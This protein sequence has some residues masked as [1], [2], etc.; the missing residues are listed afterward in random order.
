M[1]ER[2]YVKVYVILILLN[3]SCIG[4]LKTFDIKF[5]ENPSRGYLVLEYDGGTDLKKLTVA[6][7]KFATAF[8]NKH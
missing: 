8:K 6:F 3:L 5:H 1:Y 2:L 4:R 7:R